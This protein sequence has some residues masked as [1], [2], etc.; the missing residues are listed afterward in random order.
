MIC[1]KMG[2]KLLV[3]VGDE[4]SGYQMGKDFQRAYR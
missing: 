4:H 3:I 1:G 2:L